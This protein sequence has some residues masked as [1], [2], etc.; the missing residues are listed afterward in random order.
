MTSSLLSLSLWATIS[1]N[2]IPTHLSDLSPAPIL[3]YN[4]LYSI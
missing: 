3:S 2:R 4:I 1:L